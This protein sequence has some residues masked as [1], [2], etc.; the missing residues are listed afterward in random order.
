[1]L[2][3]GFHCTKNSYGNLTP[4]FYTSQLVSIPPGPL[5]FT[6][7]SP[8]GLWMPEQS[9]TH[10]RTDVY[11]RWWGDRQCWADRV[12]H[13]SEWH[14]G[15]LVRQRWI[16][17]DK[18]KN[19]YNI[20]IKKSICQEE[21]EE[22]E[23]NSSIKTEPKSWK[24]TPYF[25]PL[26]PFQKARHNELYGC[27]NRC[28]MKTAQTISKMQRKKEEAEEETRRMKKRSKVFFLNTGRR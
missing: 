13:H 6:T 20:Y 14:G 4:H 2:N 5:I 17:I 27:G 1:M 12:D 18:V 11:C 24:A 26:L 7:D 9:W 16:S 28:R 23:C 8:E 10:R 3:K 21:R 15:L 19:L 22:K 25:L